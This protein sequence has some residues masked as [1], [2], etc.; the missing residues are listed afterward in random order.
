MIM[1]LRVELVLLAVDSALYPTLLAAV[2]VLLAQPRAF[3][4]LSAYLAGGLII[5]V[6][7][8]LAVVAVLQGSQ[9]LTST[10]SGLSWG[11]DLAVGAL[12]LGLALALSLR[13]DQRV[14]ARRRP[15]PL[16]PDDARHEPWTRRILGGGSVPVVFAAALALN[17]P[18]AAY[19]IALKDI[20]AHH[21]PAGVVVGLVVLFN[22]VMF[23][24][25]EIPWLGLTLAPD[26]TDRLVARLDRALTQNSRTIAIWLS[27]ALGAF[28]VV[29]GI[30]HA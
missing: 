26:R 2:V 10:R 18:G 9:A 14:R 5:S 23:A 22:A 29:R 30:V 6:A 25:A 3:A 27:A 8:G 16:S 4:L 11:A 20:A 19:L 17:L 1:A 12:A 7:V 13:V 15:R 21:H 28:L 24:L